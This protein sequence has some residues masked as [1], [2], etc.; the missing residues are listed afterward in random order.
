[1]PLKLNLGN[2]N[3]KQNLVSFVNFVLQQPI[4]E[5]GLP[6]SLSLCF[7]PRPSPI[8]F[9]PFFLLYPLHSLSKNNILTLA[10]KQFTVSDVNI[11]VSWLVKY[12][13]LILNGFLE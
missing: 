13:C 10:V 7:L 5:L 4:Q 8:Q 6:F 1:M 2:F 3:H 9:T 11:P 12:F